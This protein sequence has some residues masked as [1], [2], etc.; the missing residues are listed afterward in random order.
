MSSVGRELG[1]SLSAMT[2]NADRLERAGLVRRVAD[3]HDRRVRSLELTPR[4][5]KMMRLREETRMKRIIAV[6]EHLNPMQRQE[7]DSS[8]RLLIDASAA[9]KAQDDNHEIRRP[10]SSKSEAIL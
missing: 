10:Y 8:L 2:Q 7:T 5:K 6:L 1:V 9:S 3:G 4:G